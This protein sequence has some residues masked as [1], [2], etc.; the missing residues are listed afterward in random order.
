MSTQPGSDAS[1]MSEL[2]AALV[3]ELVARIAA[4]SSRPA[5][6]VVALPTDGA[7]VRRKRRKRRLPKML[8]RSEVEAFM[9]TFNLRAASSLRDR[10]MFELMYRAG[11]R[12]GEVTKLE[13]RDL[14]WDENGGTVRIVDGK[15]G[16][17]TAYF[18]GDV[19]APLLDRWKEKRVEL[20]VEGSRYLFCTIRDSNTTFGGPT[21]RGR[22]VS[23][24]YLEA[25]AKRKA[26]KAGLDPAKVTPHVL[27]HTFATELLDEGL[28]IRE[29]QEAVRHADLTT[30][31]L[32]THVI[33]A[34]LRAKIQRRSRNGPS[35][36]VVEGGGVR[37]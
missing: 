12:V 37:G 11:L 19:L 2:A 29:V 21:P 16:D 17:G 5:A 33:D 25:K 36:P 20:G 27:R 15:G 28:H 22:P 1:G 34:N 30:T 10:V 6:A 35:L 14:S 3:D 32:Y 23:I 7:P 26:A 18:D 8:S 24:R 31:Q 13:P 9:A 4:G